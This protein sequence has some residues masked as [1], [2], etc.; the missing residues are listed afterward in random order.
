MSIHSQD[1]N[2]VF[3]TVA[4]QTGAQVAVVADDSLLH[5]GMG[6]MHM[7]G[8]ER[9]GRWREGINKRP[10]L[11]QELPRSASSR[12]PLPVHS[13]PQLWARLVLCGLVKS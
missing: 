4:A 9:G 1:T 7:M 8:K 12:Q 11:R 6:P 3:Q 5:Y 2:V 10:N 13:R